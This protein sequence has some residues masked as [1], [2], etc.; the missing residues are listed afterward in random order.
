MASMFNEAL[1]KKTARAYGF[2][3][4]LIFRSKTDPHGGIV[5]IM[6]QI[7][8]KISSVVRAYDPLDPDLKV[9]C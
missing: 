2:D 9:G 7:W 3:V 6:G 5:V 1:L 4:E 8:S